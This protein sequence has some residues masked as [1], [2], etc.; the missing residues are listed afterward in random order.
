MLEKSDVE[1]VLKNTQVLIGCDV[2][3]KVSRT[4]LTLTGRVHSP[5]QKGEAERIAWK[6]IGVWSVV[7]EL[8]IDLA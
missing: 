6:A 5:D 8:V 3:V 4:K 1:N 2:K 7:N